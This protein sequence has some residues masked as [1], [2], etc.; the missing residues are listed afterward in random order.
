MAQA[1]HALDYET[2]SEPALVERIVAG[3]A[4]AARTVIRRNN[5]RL[6]RTAWSILKNRSEAEEAVQEAYLKAFASLDRFQG[7]AALSTW[8]TRIV[9]NE[10]ITRTRAARRRTELLRK[11][12]LAVLDEHRDRM[13]VPASLAGAPDEALARRQLGQVLQAA[14]ARLPEPFRVVFVLK[15]IE[16]ASAQEIA[17]VL[18][19]PERTVRTRLFRARRR[20][21]ADLGPQLQQTLHESLAFAGADCDALTARVLA[22]LENARPAPGP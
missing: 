9:V 22:A 12:G 21:R 6:Y 14:I 7:D 2:L 16:D 1:A 17:D 20:L 18:G 4:V 10:A 15:E 8:L 19:V 5:Q 3:D 11:E 13:S